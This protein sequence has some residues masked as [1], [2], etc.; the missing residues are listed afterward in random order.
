[1]SETN[2]TTKPD[3]SIEED[4]IP[5][6]PLPEISLPDISLKPGINILYLVKWIIT[7]QSI[8]SVQLSW[9]PLFV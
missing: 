7:L 6:N 9:N 4:P 2:E 3:N 1:M 5:E 8:K